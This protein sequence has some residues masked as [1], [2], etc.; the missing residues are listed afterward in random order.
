MKSLP[1]TQKKTI[2]FVPIIRI[3]LEKPSAFRGPFQGLLCKFV[4]FNL[5][6]CLLF[7]PSDKLN[8][9]YY[10]AK[11]FS[12]ASLVVP[13]THSVHERIETPVLTWRLSRRD[14]VASSR[15]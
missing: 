2:I 9:Y 3:P 15:L 7:M 10:T 11:F 5:I 6:Y 14:F 4:L 12:F 8:Y 13:S 1:H